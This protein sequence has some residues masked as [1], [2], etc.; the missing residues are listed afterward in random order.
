MTNH[1]LY[2]RQ[3]GGRCAMK[4]TK[5]SNR[6]S[7]RLSGART[8]SAS[9][10]LS[11]KGLWDVLA[12]RPAIVLRR[13]V[14]GAV[15]TK[16]LEVTALAAGIDRLPKVL[17]AWRGARGSAIY[18]LETDV[19]TFRVAHSSWGWRADELERE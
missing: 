16:A 7:A 8:L 11:T 3:N 6:R 9:S 19:G 17:V 1:F 15:P 10:V 13:I 4:K 5:S 18:V 2:R 12:E 14:F